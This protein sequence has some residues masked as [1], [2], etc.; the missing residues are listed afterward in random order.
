MIIIIILIII[1]VGAL[2]CFVGFLH[3]AFRRFLCKDKPP[4]PNKSGLGIVG[5]FAQM[6]MCLE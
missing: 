6:N 3:G 4:G 2:L 1:H 5:K